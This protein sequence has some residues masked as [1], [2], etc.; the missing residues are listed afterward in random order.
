MTLGEALM[1]DIECKS[2]FGFLQKL[3]DHGELRQYYRYDYKEIAYQLNIIAQ[4]LRDCEKIYT[5]AGTPTRVVIHCE[6][7]YINGGETSWL[8]KKIVRGGHRVQETPNPLYN[9]GPSYNPQSKR[10]YSAYQKVNN[11]EIDM[12]EGD[13]I[14]LKDWQIELMI[15]DFNINEI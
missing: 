3:L 11:K 6:P 10:G 4:K 14:E 9:Y 5:R 2:K 7:D 8:N 12:S 15:D 13:N 1:L